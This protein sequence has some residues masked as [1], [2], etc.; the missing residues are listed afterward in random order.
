MKAERMG[1]L[2]GWEEGMGGGG[3]R[4]EQSIVL[5]Q[6]WKADLQDS[7]VGDTG[8]QQGARNGDVSV[9]WSSQGAAAEPGVNGRIWNWFTLWTNY[10]LYLVF[11]LFCHL[12]K[13]HFSTPSVRELHIA[14]VPQSTL[15]EEWTLQWPRDCEVI[16]W[17]WWCCSVLLMQLQRTYCRDF[18]SKALPQLG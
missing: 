8:K 14:G 6:I 10:T 9:G 1:S 5:R 18:P 13:K 11:L 4:G 15:N 2:Q 17:R 3:E 7:G 12:N 16:L